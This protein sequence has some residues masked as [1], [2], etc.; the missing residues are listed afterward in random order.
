MFQEER[1][2]TFSNDVER[3]EKGRKVTVSFGQW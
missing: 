1:V 3:C 2:I